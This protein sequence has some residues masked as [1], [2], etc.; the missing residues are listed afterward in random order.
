MLQTEAAVQRDPKLAFQVTSKV[1]QQKRRA[2]SQAAETLGIRGQT[3]K[4]VSLQM[5]IVRIAHASACANQY[6]GEAAECGSSE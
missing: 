4:E 2:S 6:F 5:L 1:E 3:V